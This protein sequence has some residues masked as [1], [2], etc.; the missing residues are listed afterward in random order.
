VKEVECEVKTIY[1]CPEQS[2]TIYCNVTSDFTKLYW[3][4]S[5]DYV[6]A[7]QTVN[8]GKITKKSPHKTY[9]SS[10]RFEVQGLSLKIAFP[11]DG[12]Q[13]YCD[14]VSRKKEKKQ[15]FT[16]VEYSEPYPD[17]VC[18]STKDTNKTKSRQLRSSGTN[19]ITKEI[20]ETNFVC[21]NGRTILKCD[22]GQHDRHIAEYWEDRYG[23]LIVSNVDGRL[24][25]TS[26]AR[27]VFNH[28]NSTLLIQ[29]VSTL[30]HLFVCKTVYKNEDIIKRFN[31]LEYGNYSLC[32]NY[33]FSK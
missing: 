13:F 5:T 27:Y 25:N 21:I 22:N 7:S 1:F 14:V 33:S 28:M 16:L 32:C 17:G 8:K 26:D 9:S 29:N 6:V 20:N 30:D 23:K 10:D 12:E 19:K 2:A 24:S 18:S 31:L 3:K 4:N 11:K 15:H